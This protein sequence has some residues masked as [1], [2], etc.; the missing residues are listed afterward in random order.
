MIVSLHARLHLSSLHAN[1][2]RVIDAYRTGNIFHQIVGLLCL[3]SYKLQHM[4]EEVE[5][6]RTTI[7]VWQL[8]PFNLLPLAHDNWRAA[9]LRHWCSAF[10]KTL[11][12]LRRKSIHSQ[13]R[14]M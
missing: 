12:N 3:K 14:A 9:P 1:A 4:R 5:N 6:I 7:K 13:M 2:C 11:F 10:L 8:R